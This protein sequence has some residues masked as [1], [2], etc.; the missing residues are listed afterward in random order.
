M[1]Y[2][3]TGIPMIFYE[4]D[5]GSQYNIVTIAEEALRLSDSTDLRS[6]KEFFKLLGWLK[7]NSQ[8]LNDSSVIFYNHYDW[9]NG[10]IK[11]PWRSA[12]NQGRVMQCFTKA[13]E[14]TADTCFLVFARKCMNSLYTEVKD[15]GVTYI[16]NNGYW[17][18]EYADDDV[19]ET[20]V[21]N[22]MIVVLQALSDYYKATRDT[23]A[24]FLFN[25][26][27]ES[28]KNTINLYDNK[29]HSNYDILG[30]PASSWYHAFHIKLLGFL[31]NET[32]DPIFNE[33][34]QKWLQYKEPS[35]LSQLCRKPSNI[36]VFTVFT[37]FTGA[38]TVIFLICYFWYKKD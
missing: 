6:E 8:P 17:Y 33:Y 21:L 34:R 1:L 30:K 27:V 5:L 25:R 32:K 11:A 28:V 36:G 7:E 19:P 4:G 13:Y 16:D 31:I 18:E 9:A 35:Y 14:K 37:I 10:V 22:G 3:S 24:L 29:G 23:S 20:R 12:M 38:F 15:G 26:G 2:D